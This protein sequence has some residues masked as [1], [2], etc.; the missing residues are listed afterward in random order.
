M[1]LLWTI[2]AGGDSSQRERQPGA[3]A[4]SFIVPLRRAACNTAPVRTG[5]FLLIALQVEAA[6]YIVA[7]NGRDSNP[8]TLER[9]FRT[10][11][12]GVAVARPGDTVAVREGVYSEAVLVWDKRATSKAPIRIAAYRGEKAVIDGKG[13]RVKNA[14]VMIGDSSWIRF[15]G[16]EVRNSPA[17]GIVLY[18]VRSVAVRGNEVHH[19]RGGGI[20]A[21]GG[22]ILIENNIVH[23]NVL[24]NAS[25]KARQWGQALASEDA[26]GV[27]IAGN[28][29]YENHG[30]GID[31][32]RTDRVVITRNRVADNF[33]VNVYLD[34]AQHATVDRNLIRDTGNRAFHRGG[35][36]AFGI[37]MANE[38]YRRQN[39]L[40]D[41]TVTN[42]IILRTR[43]G[44]HYSDSEYRGGLH[45]TLIAHNT[46]YAATWA[47]IVLGG[48]G[49]R[50]AGH[51]TTTV[52][53]NVIV[54]RSGA[55]FVARATT[56]VSFRSNL[57]WGGSRNTRAAG[58]GDVL[59][60]P[61]F[62]DP[63]GSDAEDYRLRP[64]SPARDKARRV[65]PVT[66]DYFGN[67]RGSTPDLGAHEL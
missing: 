25:G 5:L 33:S 12:R 32:I 4:E 60:D 43:A 50:N 39:P 46:I 28:R 53:N 55:A 64:A 67:R 27:M 16:F 9:P 63:G 41:I 1:S 7:A 37:A 42:N 51:D 20:H 11:K 65:S 35:E 54:Q 57:W 62:T 6:T 61:Q 44:I 14:L 56:G 29:V 15:D 40:T 48:T 3:W 31:A 24:E 66:T 36:P 17:A 52:T 58:S 2:T 26:N 38:R 59:A 22:D 34:N 49:G 30:E 8:G 45:R 19:S 21:S 23:H 18:D 13:V 10:I 47:A